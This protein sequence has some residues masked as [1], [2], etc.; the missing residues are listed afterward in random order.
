MSFLYRDFTHNIPYIIKEKFNIGKEK[1]SLLAIHYPL[2]FHRKRE[3]ASAFTSKG[4]ITLEAALVVPI[5]FFA[6][7]CLVYLLEV[8]SIQ[9]TMR[10]AI[11]SVG[12]E[13]AQE[14]YSSP[15]IST[16]GIQQHII[17]N[18][19]AEKLDKS[20]VSGGSKGINCNNSM[21]NWNTAV[22]D[23]SVQYQLE[24][25]I[26]M[27]QIPVI[28]R[29]ETLRV[30]GWTG[31]AAGAEDLGQDAVVYV[32]DYGLVYHKSM[33]CT[34]LEL[35]LQAVRASEIES[36]RSESGAKYY[37]CEFCGEGPITAGRVYITD[38]GNR[39]HTSL[40]CSK[41]KRN[42]YAVPLDEVYGL[43][44]CSKCVK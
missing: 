12:K 34:Y 7:L 10:N 27:F 44:G 19:G 5:F 29:E 23:L 26:L 13:I 39:F 33:N 35:S 6:M 8:M 40:D 41:V 21:S 9:T 4:S 16:Y 28:S 43:G 36:L 32:T 20:I 2:N 14:A 25:P 30:K 3:R 22:I 37:P 18:I 42:I 38:Y 15:M 1:D 11:Y 31:Y 17:K 24:I